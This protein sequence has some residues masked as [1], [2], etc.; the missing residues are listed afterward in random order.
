MKINVTLD[1]GVRAKALLTD[2]ALSLELSVAV[3]YGTKTK[4][5]CVTTEAIPQ[6][7]LAAL[8][9][10]ISKLVE[11]KLPALLEKAQ[12]NA[13]EAMRLAMAKGEE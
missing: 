8:H 11:Q 6:E 4:R 3:P 13:Q 5:S 2:G 7:Q 9:A 12:A 1:V 10:E